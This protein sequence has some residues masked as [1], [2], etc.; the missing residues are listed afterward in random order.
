M[1]KENVATN[2][3]CD[4]SSVWGAIALLTSRESLKLSEFS[5]IKYLIRTLKLGLGLK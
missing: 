3:E 1:L 4:N 5:K 2:E